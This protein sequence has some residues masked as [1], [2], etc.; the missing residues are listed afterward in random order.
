[1]IFDGYDYLQFNIIFWCVLGFI[2]LNMG[3]TPK[4]ASLMGK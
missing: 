2:R 3:Y 4:I 1:M